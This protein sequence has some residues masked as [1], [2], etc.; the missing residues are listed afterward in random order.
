MLG[1]TQ[2]ADADPSSSSW[3]AQRRAENNRGAGAETYDP[4]PAIAAALKAAGLI[5][6]KPTGDTG[7]KPFDPRNVITAALRSV[8]P[9]EGLGAPRPRAWHRQYRHHARRWV[10]SPSHLQVT[11]GMPG[12]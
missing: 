6:D 1:A 4:R 8:R 7:S 3:G 5:G 9:L 12:A 2:S 10:A 11:I